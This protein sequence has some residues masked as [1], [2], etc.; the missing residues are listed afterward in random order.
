MKIATAEQM[1]YLDKVT[2]H[3][4]GVPSTLLMERAAQ[5][6]LEAC[7]DLLEEPRGKRC[8]V[9]CGCLLYTSRCV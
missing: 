2:I 7:L 3:D 8:A 6:I 9:F 1:R 4:R 5:G